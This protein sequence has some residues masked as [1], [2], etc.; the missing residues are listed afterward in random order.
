M[1]DIDPIQDKETGDVEVLKP[2]RMGK[3]RKHG[4][5]NPSVC[6]ANINVSLQYPYSK[7]LGKLAIKNNRL[8]EHNLKPSHFRF[9][10]D[11]CEVS[12]GTKNGTCFTE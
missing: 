8:L 7:L 4:C 11:P 12:G 9:P 3:L 6:N 10:N 1:A 5:E 2:G